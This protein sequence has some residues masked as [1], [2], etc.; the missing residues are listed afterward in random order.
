MSTAT[1]G[2]AKTVTVSNAS[3]LLMPAVGGQMTLEDDS[4]TIVI[5][6]TAPEYLVQPV[7]G[8]VR[9]GW[10]ASVYS[11]LSDLWLPEQPI[12][13]G[14]SDTEAPFLGQDVRDAPYITNAL[15]SIRDAGQG[16]D[17]LVYVAFQCKVVSVVAR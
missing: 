9:F 3:Q 7:S 13:N 5:E 17:A 14:V 6:R 4:Y 1:W 16:S 2:Y 11:L 10:K 15:Y 8:N 12:I